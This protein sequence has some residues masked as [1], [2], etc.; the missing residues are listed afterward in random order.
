MGLLLK[1]RYFKIFLF[2]FF[3]FIIHTGC[4]KE[5]E[6]FN[7]K[8][9]SS[10]DIQ[11]NSLINQ[12]DLIK[13][14]MLYQNASGNKYSIS[15]LQY[16]ISEISLNQSNGYQF[17]SEDVFY[18]DAFDPETKHLIIKG[19]KPG[20]YTSIDF[21]IG[22]NS[23]NNV[24][25]KISNTIQN[26]NMFW[27]D[28]MGG[29]YHFLKF[30]G[31]YLNAENKQKGFALHLGTNE[32]L[33]KHGTL[34]HQFEFANN[35]VDSLNLQMNINKWFDGPSTYNFLI[36]GNYSMGIVSL[37]QKLQSNGKAVFEIRN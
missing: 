1:M 11:I 13:D 24:H 30:E 19:I 21:H 22:L 32:M 37:M 10:L 29:G 36:D 18:L 27:P 26:I 14:S 3:Y 8:E 28:E 17:K 33:I 2:P 25:G 31:N 12:T 7:L 23:S 20:V 35:K 34:N 16:Y 15:R 9:S 5:T 4:K 6:D